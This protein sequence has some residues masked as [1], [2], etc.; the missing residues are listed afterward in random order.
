MAR[1]LEY[2]TI[3]V[4]PVGEAFGTNRLSRDDSL[5]FEDSSVW[6]PDILDQMHKA[7]VVTSMRAIGPSSASNDASAAFSN[8]NGSDGHR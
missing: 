5:L 3:K 6:R 2:D 7:F 1:N 8:R 4:Y